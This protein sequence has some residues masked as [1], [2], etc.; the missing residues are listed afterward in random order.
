MAKIFRRAAN[1]VMNSR[2]GHESIGL[3]I[4]D[5]KVVYESYQKVV[6]AQVDGEINALELCDRFCFNFNF[7]YSF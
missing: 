7:N 4:S 6:M 1:K 5:E 3:L 2:D